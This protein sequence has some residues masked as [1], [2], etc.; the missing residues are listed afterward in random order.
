[1]NNIQRTIEDYTE[2]DVNRRLH[3]FLEHRNLR[4][5]FMEIEQ[6]EVD[7][8]AEFPTKKIRGGFGSV[9]LNAIPVLSIVSCIRKVFQTR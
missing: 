5:Q 7:P 4:D 2:A 6:T 1:M 3:L 8:A 9:K